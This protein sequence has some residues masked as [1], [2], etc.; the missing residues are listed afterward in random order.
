MVNHH[1][2]AEE[3]NNP[4]SFYS[5]CPKGVLASQYIPL[6]TFHHKY[7]CEG[8]TGGH[9]GQEAFQSLGGGGERHRE[10]ELWVGVG[11]GGGIA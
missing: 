2:D 3:W 7:V 4:D 5:S 11:W 10:G 1:A 9:L 8:A 6:V